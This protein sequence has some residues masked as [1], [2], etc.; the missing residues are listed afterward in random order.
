MK[1]NP[2]EQKKFIKSLAG[3]LKAFRRVVSADLDT[4]KIW[5]LDSREIIALDVLIGAVLDCDG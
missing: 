3:K 2:E 1:N 4:E 5:I